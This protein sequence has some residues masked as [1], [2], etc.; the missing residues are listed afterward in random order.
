MKGLRSAPQGRKNVATGVSPWEASHDSIKA[1]EGRQKR[2]GTGR[3][4][5]IIR[6]PYRAL[7]RYVIVGEGDVLLPRLEFCSFRIRPKREYR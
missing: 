5:A 4:A 3:F 7:I 6:R 2:C 1:P